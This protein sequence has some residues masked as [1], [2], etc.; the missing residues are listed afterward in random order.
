LSGIVESKNFFLR[1]SI[2]SAYSESMQKVFNIYR[3]YA[4]S[5]EAYMKNTTKLGLFVVHKII[6]G[7]YIKLFGEYSESI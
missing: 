1:I 2:L 3:E 6:H 4:E 5:I 7:K